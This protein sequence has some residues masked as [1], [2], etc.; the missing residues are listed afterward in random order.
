LY[1]LRLFKQSPKGLALYTSRYAS[2]LPLRAT[3][4][5]LRV[6]WCALTITPAQGTRLYQKA[7]VPQEPI[8]KNN[9]ARLVTAGR[10]RW[11]GE[12]ETNNTL[13]TKGYHREP[14]FGHGQQ[15]LA[16]LFATFTLLAF[17]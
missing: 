8:T 15:H 3:D 6:N 12:N 2:H 7:C 17:L 16:S 11:K 9:V 4:D 10:P 1:V 13:T 14:N 5:A